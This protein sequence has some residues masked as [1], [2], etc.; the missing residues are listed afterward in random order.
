MLCE[1]FI[2]VFLAFPF[3]NKMKGSGNGNLAE[4]FIAATSGFPADERYDLTDFTGKI[5]FPLW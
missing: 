1:M 4:K 5:A 3:F 2:E